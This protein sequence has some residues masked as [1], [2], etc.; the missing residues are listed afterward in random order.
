M[1]VL[2]HVR[3]LASYQIAKTHCLAEYLVDECITWAFAS[4]KAHQRH[5]EFVEDIWRVHARLQ[6][7]MTIK[8]DVKITGTLQH[9]PAIPTLSPVLNNAPKL[10][11]KQ[12]RSYLHPMLLSL[13]LQRVIWTTN[14][15]SALMQLELLRD[16]SCHSYQHSYIAGAPTHNDYAEED[17]G[18][19][20]QFQLLFP[21][22]YSFR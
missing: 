13:K 11:Q 6:P 20:L 10:K 7:I 17:L 9:A 22:G 8:L 4:D 21:G 5:Q 15:K 16:E 1:K 14:S 18:S 3:W 19:H 12:R 2:G